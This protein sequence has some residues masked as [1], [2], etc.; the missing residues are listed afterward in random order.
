MDVPLHMVEAQNLHE[1]DNNQ[2][3]IIIAFLPFH[4]YFIAKRIL[5]D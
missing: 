1:L 4:T 3:F 2:V 5:K